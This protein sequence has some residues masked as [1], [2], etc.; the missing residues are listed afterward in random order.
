MKKDK[1]KYL[2]V[3]EDFSVVA[4]EIENTGLMDGKYYR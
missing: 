1:S 2:E 3:S 4:T